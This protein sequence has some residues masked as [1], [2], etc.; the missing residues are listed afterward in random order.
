[1]YIQ[2]YDDPEAEI[3]TTDTLLIFVN[4]LQS[5]RSEMLHK[6]FYSENSAMT[7]FRMIPEPY[8]VQAV[9]LESI[10]PQ[11]MNFEPNVP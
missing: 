8:L 4:I 9:S 2:I 11:E 5:T 1:V 3:F 6:C 7:Q 10:R